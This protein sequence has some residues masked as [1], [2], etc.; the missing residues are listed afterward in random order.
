[1]TLA[2]LY[3]SKAVL[4]PVYRS[5]ETEVTSG[6]ETKM[7]FQ[8]IKQTLK[9]SQPHHQ[10]RGLLSLEMQIGHNPKERPKQTNEFDSGS[11]SRKEQQ[12]DLITH[13][14]RALGLKEKK[15]GNS[16]IANIKES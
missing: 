2:F 10:N 11:G 9:H 7:Q 8:C 5:K 6:Y 13:S 1:M 16:T 4:N 12:K 14:G 15:V 3:L